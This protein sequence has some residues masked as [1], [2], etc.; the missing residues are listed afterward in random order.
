MKLLE[1]KYHSN[2]A[3][4]L[5]IEMSYFMERISTFSGRCS[6]LEKERIQSEWL[7]NGVKIN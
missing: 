7:G 4:S 5:K 2:L 3:I 1:S 6:D